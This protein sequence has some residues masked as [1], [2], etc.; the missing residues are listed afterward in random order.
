MS[1]N[2][3]NQVYVFNQEQRKQEQRRQDQRFNPLNQVYVFN[4]S[5]LKKS[6]ILDGWT[7]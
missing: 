2:P 3:L 5:P 4:F 7:F 6:S 1:F